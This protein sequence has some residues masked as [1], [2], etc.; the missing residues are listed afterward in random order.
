MRKDVGFRTSATAL[1]REVLAATFGVKAGN[2]SQVS[3][4]VKD[5]LMEGKVNPIDPIQKWKL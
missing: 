3:V 4:T 5:P 2:R 1:S